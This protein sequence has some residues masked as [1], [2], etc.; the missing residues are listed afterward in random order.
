MA[1]KTTST[2]KAEKKSPEKTI[3]KTAEKATKPAKKTV[4]KKSSS[5]NQKTC[6]ASA[7]KLSRVLVKYN[8]GWGNQLF[9]RGA[10]ADLSWEKGVPMQ[11]VGEDEWLWEQLVCRGSLSFKILINDQAWSTGEDMILEAGESITVHPSF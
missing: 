5:K 2:V 8:A 1:R 7:S 6:K 11:C 9:I 4:A 3:K 10:G